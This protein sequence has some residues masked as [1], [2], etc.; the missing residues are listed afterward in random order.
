MISYVMKL[1][2]PI[3]SIVV[4]KHTS[5]RIYIAKPRINALA[6]L[7][8]IL[9]NLLNT[10]PSEPTQPRI[11]WAVTLVSVIKQGKVPIAMVQNYV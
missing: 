4:T 1:L 7:T 5:R 8:H 3:E 6:P 2:L 11:L 10:E 9:L